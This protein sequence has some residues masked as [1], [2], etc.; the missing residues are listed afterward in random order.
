MDITLLSESQL[1]TN[2]VT[3]VDPRT[4]ED[5]DIRIRVNSPDSKAY[6][7]AMHKLS[8]QRLQQMSRKGSA[9]TSERVQ[10]EA[11]EMLAANIVGWE[12][13]EENGEPL[14]FSHDAAI[15]LLTRFK[16][17]REQIDSFLGDRKNFF[18]N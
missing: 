6:Q 14:P 11:I 12:G 3:I 8:N 15:D 5:T 9:V 4:G 2:V 7:Q 18:A 10:R 16:W 1:D 17:L 13:V